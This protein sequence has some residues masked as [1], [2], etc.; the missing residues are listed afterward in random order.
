LKAQEGLARDGRA[1]RPAAVSCRTHELTRLPAFRDAGT[2]RT[3]YYDIEDY[4]QAHVTF[5]DGTVADI[6][7]TEVVLGGVH[8]W[9]EVYA[10]NHRTRCNL[11]P[12]DALT[13]YNPREEF[14]KDV[15]VVEK[16]GT[17]QGW[18]HPAPDEEWQHGFAQEMQDFIEC[19]AHSRRPQCG[20]ELGYDTVAVLY[21]GYLSAE[22]GG[23][24]VPIAL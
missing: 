6:F 18:S 23:A 3:D 21:S 1:I 24:D 7:S 8:N 17:K 16:I 9:L 5:T 22:R 4:C 20:A 15:Y 13:T 10:N 19:I 14:F 11:N 12:I 2:L